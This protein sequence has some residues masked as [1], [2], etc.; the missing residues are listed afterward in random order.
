MKRTTRSATVRPAITAG[1]TILFLGPQGSGK[2]TQ[3]SLLG[4]RHGLHHVEMGA[5]L[6]GLRHRKHPS[7]F[8]RRVA[9]LI[10]RG[11]LVPSRWVVYLLDE[12]LASVPRT[13][14]LVLD[15]SARRLPEARAISRVL[16]KHGRTLD[17]VLYLTISRNE[18]VRRLTRR[19]S[20]LKKR[21]ILT[22]GKDVKRPTDRCPICGSRIAQRDDDT[23]AAITKRLALFRK[24]TLPSI[25]YFRERGLVTRIHGERS[26]ASVARDIEH[27]FQSIHR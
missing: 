13:S 15:G 24:E 9:G 14:G 25:R 23:P 2:G 3:A 5:I 11:R 10:D 6:R 27:A 4:S 8:A 19:W 7:P 17:L 16:K 21:H 22:M 1:P 20:C 18:S 12:H 26:V